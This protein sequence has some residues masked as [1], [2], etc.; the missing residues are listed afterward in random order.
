MTELVILRHGYSEGNKEKR[1]SGQ[2]NVPLDNV[3][4]NQAESVAKFI[5][6]NFKVDAIYSSDLS[7]A[8]DTVKPLADKLGLEIVKDVN[9]REVD[10]GKWQGMLIEDAKNEFPEEFAAYKE[11]VG[12]SRFPG[13]ESY[14]EAMNRGKDVIEKIAKEN[15]GKTVV[16]AT[17]GGIIRTLRAAW[18]RISL[19]EIKTIPHVPNASATVVAYDNGKIN[20]IKIGSVEHLDDKT[21]EE[22]VK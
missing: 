18:N 17:H 16:I 21:T 2:M 11:N 12:R 6:D 5:A 1:F 13:G 4:K 9:L 8:Y 22:G 10:V 14:E 15:D 19:D 3:G 7:R 20:W